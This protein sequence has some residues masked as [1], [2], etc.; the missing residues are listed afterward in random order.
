MHTSIYSII[1][2]VTSIFIIS[3]DVI[4]I[5]GSKN[6]SSKTFSF[7]TFLTAVWVLSQGFFI[8]FLDKELAFCL[9]R[10]QYVLGIMIAIG[11]YH[12]SHI[13]PYDK[14]PTK[15]SIIIS[16]L[17]LICFIYLYFFTKIL[18]SNVYSIGGIGRWAWSFGKLHLLFDISFYS[19][20]IFA[21]N[22]LY[23]TYKSETGEL[24]SN[25]K[26]M[27]WA[28]FL[29]II[30]PTM[31]N[32]L[33]PSFG[34]YQYN[35]IGPIT[36]FIWV[37]IVAYSIIKYHQMD[38][39]AIMTEVLAIGMMIIF[40]INIFTDVSDGLWVRIVTF[41]IFIILAF[42]LIK[43][44]LREVR[45]REALKLLNSTLSQKVAEQ[46][47]EVKLAYEL[48]SKARRDLAKLNETKDQ[49][50]MITQHNLRTP[51]SSIRSELENILSGAYGKISKNTRRALNNTGV[52][53]KHLTRI[54]DDFLNITTLKVGSQI[55]KLS[56]DNLKQSIED[57]L[58]ELK[59]D[60]H[61][62]NLS[63]DYPKNTE[64][65]PILKIDINKIREVLLIIIEN[66][67]KY[68]VKNGLIVIKTEVIEDNFTM[69]IK[70]TGIGII[71]EDKNNL[72]E[73]LFFRSKNAKS[74]NPKG[75]GIG[76][77]VSKAILKAHHG[78]IEIY[79]EGENMGAS[80]TI[81]IPVD[82]TKDLID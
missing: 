24:R 4:I 9:I 29:G 47:E 79:S 78:D 74:M 43:V 13:Y 52:A 65:W 18:V 72:F 53:I 19:L 10:F 56:S 40:F 57:I 45:Q 70:N 42:Y 31:A 11:F 51:V 68:N 46:T 23:K 3:L 81:K 12:F 41:I 5:I 20:W 35:W 62:N 27:F 64:S 1:I 21:L 55:L 61:T 7:I 54:V 73:R 8:T 6:L 71:S 33:L 16:I 26:N 60:I 82:F 25:L 32:I 36:S 15:K 77:S 80:V 39:R 48:E 30:P 69:T 75:M 50:I 67:I 49:F 28:L 76:L 44:S 34:E 37:F 38:V 63:I 66:A 2:W 59:I 58:L 14:K 17:I 22:K